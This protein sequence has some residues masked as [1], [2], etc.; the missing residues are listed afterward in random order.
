[1]DHPLSP[2]QNI[3]AHLHSLHLP[4]LRLQLQ[5]MDPSRSPDR[6]NSARLGPLHLPCPH[7]HLS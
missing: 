4:C 7:P 2:Y 6:V 1:M 3:Q 5:V